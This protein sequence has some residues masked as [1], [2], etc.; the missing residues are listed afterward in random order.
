MQ[1]LHP[2]EQLQSLGFGP[3]QI[4]LPLQC[5]FAFMWSH[6]RGPRRDQG[7]TTGAAEEEGYVNYFFT[8]FYY[9]PFTGNK[10][11]DIVV[12]GPALV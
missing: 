7:P 9:M 6:G 10:E 4:A 12:T 8:T 5:I 2:V 3:G 1:L 11:H